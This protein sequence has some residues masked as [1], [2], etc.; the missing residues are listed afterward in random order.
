M[1]LL[2][3]GRDGFLGVRER[4]RLQWRQ[5]RVVVDSR[6]VHVLTYDQLLE[7]LSFRLHAYPLLAQV[8]AAKRKPRGSSR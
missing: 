1:A 5:Q 4:S 7:D 8:D 3:I 6:H 2:V